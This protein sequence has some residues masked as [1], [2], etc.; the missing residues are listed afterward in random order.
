[1]ILATDRQGT[2]FIPFVF[3]LNALFREY[4]IL[5][6]QAVADLLSIVLA[7]IVLKKAMARV[8]AAEQAAQAVPARD[9]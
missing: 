8:H 2:C 1:M 9:V 5:S 4:G 3:L 7:L 6:I